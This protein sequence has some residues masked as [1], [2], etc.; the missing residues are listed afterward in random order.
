MPSSVIRRFSYEPAERRLRVVFTSGDVYEYADV[1]PEVVEALK[2][3]P[4]KGEVFGLQIRDR[5]A[6]R[7]ISRGSNQPLIG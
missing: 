1:P 7:R 6:Y 3:A 2:V 5:Y 4:S